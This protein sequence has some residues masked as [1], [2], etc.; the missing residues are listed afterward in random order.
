MAGIY[1]HIPFC[2]KACHYCNFHFSTQL[3]YIDDLVDAICKDIELRHHYLQRTSLSSHYLSDQNNINGV[4]ENNND[5]YQQQPILQTIYFG[6][7][8]P[9]LLLEKH[10]N[11]IFNII[12]RYFIISNDA[13]VTLEANP[14]DVNTYNLGL[15]KQYGINRLSIGIQSFFDED[16][17]AMNRAHN[18]IEAESCVRM[19]RQYDFN[20]L[21]IDL[22][23][24]AHTTSDEMW[25]KNI[26][27][28]LD[29][30]VQHISSYC[31][32]IE[33]KTAYGSW[34]KSNKMKPIDEDKASRQ[35]DMLMISL[36]MAGYDHY[37]IS[38]FAKPGKYAVH[39]TNYW[40]GI[41]YLGIGPSAHSFDGGSRSWAVAHNLDYIKKL[42]AND[43][44]YVEIE[45]LSTDDAYNE[46]MMTGLRTMWG[47]NLYDLKSKFGEDYF[48]HTLAVMSDD[49]VKKNAI[50]NQNILKLTDAGKHF[51]DNIAAEFFKINED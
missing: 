31:L 45:I 33:E 12:S 4:D 6:G 1:I 24:G 26:D 10:I 13:E 34:L 32:T 20:N 39:N 43:T 9:S 5:L 15:W 14:D 46:Y 41:P 47:V 42:N 16:L 3:N 29:L 51:A 36:N 40:K 48:Q 7:G 44:S 21:S 23:Y 35:F 38:N 2:K 30:E 37:E 18:A 25:Q 8:T 49:W 22:I 17:L 27:L 50:Y 11:K 19:A 28:A